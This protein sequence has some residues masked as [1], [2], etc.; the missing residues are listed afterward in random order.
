MI[1]LRRD[2]DRPNATN[3]LL[4]ALALVDTVYLIACVLI[5][6][7]KTVNDVGDLD[8]PRAALTRVFPYVEPHA[9]ALAST[10]QTATVWLVL[11]VT[12]DRYVAVC[13]PLKVCVYNRRFGDFC[14]E[15]CSLLTENITRKPPESPN[16]RQAQ[17][18]FWIR[19]PG[20]QWLRSL[21]FL[22]LFF[23]LLLS[24]IRFFP[25]AQYT[26]PTPTRRNCF[27]AS[28]RRRRCVHEFATS[29]R[30]LPT[31]SVD[32]LET[33]QTDCVCVCFCVLTT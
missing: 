5:Q 21:F 6:P 12:V 30:R 1:V 32:N 31:D 13:R 3:W 7:L 9:W 8:G 15:P 28:R 25:N 23:L 16:V 4:Q 14:D 11:L 10:A 33:G 17:L 19:K 27:V 24:D 2:R 20:L 29:S 18:N 22:F 26:P